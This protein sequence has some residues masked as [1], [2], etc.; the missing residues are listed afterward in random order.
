[1]SLD[2]ALMVVIRHHYILKKDQNEK[3]L[4]MR[5]ILWMA[6]LKKARITAMSKGR[7]QLKR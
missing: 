7:G 4:N 2:E 3:D 5:T 6:E 1:M